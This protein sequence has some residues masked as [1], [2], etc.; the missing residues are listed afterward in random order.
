L[1]LFISDQFD[2]LQEPL[3]EL[4]LHLKFQHLSESPPPTKTKSKDVTPLG[5]NQV[6]PE[7]EVIFTNRVEPELGVVVAQSAACAG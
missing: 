5:I 7:A 6:Q 3:W 2:C 4:H 1:V